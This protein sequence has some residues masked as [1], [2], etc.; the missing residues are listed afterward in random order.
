MLTTTEDLGATY[1]ALRGQLGAYLR[2]Q[3]PDQAVA[4]DLLQQVFLKA[5]TALDERRSVG[6]VTGWLYSVAR[7]TAVDY[8]RSRAPNQTSIDDD[9]P[10]EGPDEQQLQQHLAACLAPLAE[11][12]PPIYRDTLIAT[13]FQGQSMRTLAAKAGLSTSAIKSRAA[14][15]RTL[16]K[17]KLLECCNVEMSNGAIVDYQRKG[18]SGC[19]GKCC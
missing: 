1:A 14:R 17:T 13:D 19:K 9:I 10:A 2:K 6:N 15:A 8:Y 12:L 16:L 4:E 18:A 3:V 5:L 11:S 7:T